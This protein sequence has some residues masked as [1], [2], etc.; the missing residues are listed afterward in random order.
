MVSETITATNNDTHYNM[1]KANRHLVY[2]KAVLVLGDPCFIQ[3]I[4]TNYGT[5]SDLMV[6][7]AAMSL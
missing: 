4:Y 6:I 5:L 1:K 7:A 2:I 3:V